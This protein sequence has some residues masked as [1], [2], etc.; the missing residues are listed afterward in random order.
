VCIHNPIGGDRIGNGRWLGV[1]LRAVLERADPSAQAS[2]LITRA[3]DGFTASLPLAPLRSGEWNGYVVVGLNGEPLSAQHGYPARVFVPGIYGQYTGAKWLSE[4]ELSAGPHNDY[5]SPRGWPHQPAQVQPQARIDV[6]AHRTLSGGA[7]TIAGVAWAPPYGVN[8]VEVRASDGP[9]QT[10]DLA[11]ELAP[12]SWRR[13]MATLD[14]P[15]GAH[16]IQAR[17]ISRS[18]DVQGGR[19]RPPFPLGASG[20][21]TVTI[22]V[23]R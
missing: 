12:A 16:T 10:A 1:P 21:H 19:E 9:W 14:L 15:P 22:R 11:D 8:G 13:W 5:W 23:A 4:L 17:A 6:P 7:T 20:W 3:V 18:G 2:M